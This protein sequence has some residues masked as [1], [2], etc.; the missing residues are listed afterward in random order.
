MKSNSGDVTWK[1]N[2]WIKVDG[3]LDMCN[4]GLHSS[5]HP[6]DAFSYVQ[7]EILALV[8]CRGEHLNNEDKECWREQRVIKTYKWT[9]K[10]SLKLAI[11]SAELVLKIFE[12]KYP[13]DKRPREAIEAAKKVLFKDTKKNRDA[14]HAAYTAAAHAARAADDAAHAAHAADDAAHAAHAADDAAHAAYAAY[15]AAHAAYAAY[16][17]YTAADA[18]AADDAAYAAYTAADAAYTAADAAHAARRNL[19]KKIQKYFMQIVKE[20]I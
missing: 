5:K 17:A 19:I 13:D 16:A 20:K 18:Y 2:K 1:L 14:A 3:A 10:D 9:K 7:G 12:D 8:E 11:Y 6:Y 15:A 4:W